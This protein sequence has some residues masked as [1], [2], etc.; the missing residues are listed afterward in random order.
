VSGRALVAYGDVNRVSTWGGIPYFFLQAGRRNGLF[1]AGVALHPERFRYR[2]LLWNAVRPL[3]LDR[4]GGFQFSRAHL[5]DL[6]ADRDA[7]SGI[8]EY[9]SFFQPLPPTDVVREPVSYYI[10][11]TLRQY[12]EDYRRRLGRRVHAET[13]A[14]EKEAYLSARF[15]V[16]MSRWCADGVKAFYGIPPE[17]VRVITPGANIDEASVPAATQWDG[18]LSPLRLGLIGIDWDRKGGPLL[19][20]VATK[21]Q[22][23]GHSVEVVVIGPKAS[24]LPRHPALHAIGF[25]DKARELPRFVELVRSFHFGCLLSRAEAL[26]ISILECLRLGVPVIGTAVG[27]IVDTVSED[28]GLLM[29]TE[30]TGERLTEVLAAFLQTPERYARMREAAQKG[31]SFYSWDRTSGEF[32]D[33]LGR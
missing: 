19:L 29:P 31:A 26:G 23:M 16:C 25:I 30:Q 8:S 2:R 33:L 14:R 22:R 20:D 11:A 18:E 24:A 3:T 9:V 10:D 32:L 1:Q 17:K 7:P 27:G 15:V 13:L 21:L 28:T 4:P 5:R 6:W 12:F